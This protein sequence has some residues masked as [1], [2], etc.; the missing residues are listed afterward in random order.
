MKEPKFVFTRSGKVSGHALCVKMHL[1]SEELM[2]ERNCANV[3][4]VSINTHH[5]WPTLEVVY[6]LTNGL[7]IF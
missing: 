6:V 2:R 4:T 1:Y 3:I 5:G 7:L